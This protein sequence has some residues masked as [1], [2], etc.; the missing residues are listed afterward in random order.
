M[1][2]IPCGAIRRVLHI[3]F[4]YAFAACKFAQASQSR[5]YAGPPENAAFAR[6]VT[7]RRSLP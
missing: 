2:F 7:R 1:Q 3:K 5:A 6:M 4:N